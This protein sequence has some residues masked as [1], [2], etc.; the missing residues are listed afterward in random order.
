MHACIHTYITLHYITLHYITLHYIT[1][2]YITLHYITL[3]Y[4]HTYITYICIYIY[5]HIIYISD[6]IPNKLGIVL[7]FACCQ[8]AG[9][10]IYINGHRVGDDWMIW[11]IH[12][13]GN[14][15]L[16]L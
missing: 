8:E 12:N 10:V 7:Q 5:M 16:L 4:I 6:W 1:L 13:L 14:L 9:K 15:H 3:H 11:G 2:H